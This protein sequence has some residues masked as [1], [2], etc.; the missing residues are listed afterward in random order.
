MPVVILR[1][2]MEY[3]REYTYN[4]LTS[5]FRRKLE[6]WK[7]LWAGSGK[8]RLDSLCRNAPVCGNAVEVWQTGWLGSCQ[9]LRALIERNDAAL[10]KCGF[11][12]LADEGVH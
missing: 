7:W 1:N 9:V 12:V 6:C 3:F 8:T 10:F 11:M 5:P 4:K 2:L